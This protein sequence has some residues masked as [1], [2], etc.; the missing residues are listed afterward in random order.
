[1]HAIFRPLGVSV[2]VPSLR[3]NERLRW[4][5]EL[6]NT[7]R[8]DG[9]TLAPEAALDD[10]RR[11]IGKPI[12][13]DDLFAGCRRALENGFYRVKLYFMCGL[14]GEGPADLDG[15]IDMAEEISQIGRSGWADSQRWWS[16]SRTSYPNRRRRTSGSPCKAASTSRKPTSG[17]GNGSVCGA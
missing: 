8:R 10:M 15:I 3:V 14:P 6:M 1:M 11:Q 13:N 7:D 4:I 16:T 5:S 12:S 9:L 2:S 17:C